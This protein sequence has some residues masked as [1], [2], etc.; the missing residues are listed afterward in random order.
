MTAISPV[1]S[2]NKIRRQRHDLKHVLA[3]IDAYERAG[4]H[5]AVRRF[6]EEQTASQTQ[7]RRSGWPLTRD[8]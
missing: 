1:S 4:D 3:T 2:P 7:T 6:V 5:E 8:R